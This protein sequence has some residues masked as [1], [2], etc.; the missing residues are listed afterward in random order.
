[1][2]DKMEE[3]ENFFGRLAKV[4]DVAE[5]LGISKSKVYLLMEAGD[6]EYVKIGKNRRVPWAAVQDLVKRCTV[7]R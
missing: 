5:H 4:Q 1:M 3:K 2:V 6:L 7:A